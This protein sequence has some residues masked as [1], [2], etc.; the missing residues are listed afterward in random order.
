MFGK[1]EVGDE[2]N[3]RETSG[4]SMEGKNSEWNFVMCLNNGDKIT[5]IRIKSNDKK[6]KAGKK[7]GQIGNCKF[8]LSLH[9]EV[10]KKINK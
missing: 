8:P 2:W 1:V 5:N 4:K 6:G 3:W 7:E 10:K 9:F